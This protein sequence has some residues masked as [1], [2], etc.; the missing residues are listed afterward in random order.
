MAIS[1]IDI[2]QRNSILVE[3]ITRILRPSSKQIDRSEEILLGTCALLTLIFCFRFSN[4]L[5]METKRDIMHEFR[6]QVPAYYKV[7]S[8]IYPT[9]ACFFERIYS[10]ILEEDEDVH[11]R[12]AL[13]LLSSFLVPYELPIHAWIQR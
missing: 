5:C 11:H 12:S 9:N 7:T 10:F 4:F 8:K 6:R 3:K 1:C 2:T 13:S